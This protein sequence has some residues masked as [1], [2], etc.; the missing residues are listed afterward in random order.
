M[1]NG[2]V[3]RLFGSPGAGEREGK[4]KAPEGRGLPGLFYSA[5]RAGLSEVDRA[6]GVAC[7]AIAGTDEGCFVI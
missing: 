5:W 7:K 3:P 2:R 6:V 4:Q 1:S